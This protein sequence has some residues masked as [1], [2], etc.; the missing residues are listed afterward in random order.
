MATYV[1]WLAQ[2]SLFVL[3]LC[4]AV[5]ALVGL[6]RVIRNTPSILDYLSGKRR[7]PDTEYEKCERKKGWIQAC[8][9]FVVSMVHAGIALWMF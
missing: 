3:I 5:L 2:T 4:G 6:I 8:L 7:F 9:G 1:A